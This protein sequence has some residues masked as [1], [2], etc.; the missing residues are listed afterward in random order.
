MTTTTPRTRRA[1]VARLFAPLL[2]TSLPWP[3]LAVLDPDLDRLARYRLDEATLLK[4]ETALENLAEV[5]RKNPGALRRDEEGS[6]PGIV[7]I[8][9]FYD[10]RPPLREAITRAGLTPYNFTV[11]ML[12]WAQAAMAHRFTQ[13]MPKARRDQAIADSG[14]AAANVEFVATHQARLQAVGEKIQAINPKGCAAEACGAG[15]ARTPRRGGAGA[16]HRQPAAAP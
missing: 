14:V 3:A 16:R 2:L 15:A 5:A 10:T 6:D 4:F 9:T 12:V 1:F 11:F 13:S 7:D 8:A